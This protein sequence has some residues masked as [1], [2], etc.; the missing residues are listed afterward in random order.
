M[1]VN[2]NCKESRKSNGIDRNPGM[3]LKESAHRAVPTMPYVACVFVAKP[4]QAAIDA[5]GLLLVDHLP[6]SNETRHG[7]ASMN[8]SANKTP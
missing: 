8:A 7:T 2:V 4:G 6:T 1:N 5:A 3:R